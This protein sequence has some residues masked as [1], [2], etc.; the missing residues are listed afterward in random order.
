MLSFIIIQ[1]HS[2]NRIKCFRVL[3]AIY[4]AVYSIATSRAQTSETIVTDPATNSFVGFLDLIVTPDNQVLLSSEECTFNNSIVPCM[5]LRSISPAGILTVVDTIYNQ[6]PSSG[7]LTLLDNQFLLVTSSSKGNGSIEVRRYDVATSTLKDVEY[8]VTEADGYVDLSGAIAQNGFLYLYGQFYYSNQEK[9]SA[10]YIQKISLS[11]HRTEWHVLNHSVT[12]SNSCENLQINRH[13]ELMFSRYNIP[14]A[15]NKDRKLEIV[16][17]DTADGR[18]TDIVSFAQ[19]KRRT[20]FATLRSGKAALF[21]GFDPRDFLISSAGPSIMILTSDLDSILTGVELYTNE[22]VQRTYDISGI[23]QLRSGS[24]L[25][26]GGASDRTYF[27]ERDSCLSD[28]GWMGMFNRSADSLMWI[29][30]Y[31]YNETTGED[32][33]RDNCRTFNIENIEEVDD[34]VIQASGHIRWIKDRNLVGSPL[35]LKVDTFGCL[36]GFPCESKIIINEPDATAPSMLSPGYVWNQ[37]GG[38]PW[39]SSN[40]VRRYRVSQEPTDLEGQRYYQIETSSVE[41]DDT[42]WRSLDNVYLR[43]EEQ[44]RVYVHAPGRDKNGNLENDDLIYNFTLEVGDTFNVPKFTPL[45]WWEGGTGIAIV[46]AVDSVILDNGERRKRLTLGC[47]PPN[48][49]SPLNQ[50]Y[51]IEGMGAT[52]GMFESTFLCSADVSGPQLLCYSL[53]GQVLYHTQSSCAESTVSTKPI[54]QNSALLRLYPNPTIGRLSVKGVN[55]PYAVRVFDLTGRV[56][57]KSY[58]V[59]NNEIDLS[60]LLT[61]IYLVEITGISGIRSVSRIIKR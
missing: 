54:G 20:G 29:R 40:T 42:L 10:S 2:L 14:F 61:G 7:A 15:A 48:G 51:W 35:L 58:N 57:W 3:L 50:Q 8:Y 24:V 31:Q 53:N 16:K 33:S 11:N 18:Q 1:L 17:L 21:M 19:N 32:D 30:L 23:K 27:N 12:G 25:A 45:D 46:T 28:V 34:D 49:G 36:P 56:V 55:F 59:N 22:Y 4:I 38:Y 6:I 13:G 26:Y 37:V 44:G 60:T 43:E 47:L 5:S 39:F 41:S 9:G 52:G